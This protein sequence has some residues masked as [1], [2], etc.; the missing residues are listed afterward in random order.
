MSSDVTTKAK[1]IS[2]SSGFEHGVRIGL[3]AY[4]IVHLLI[5]WLGLQAAFGEGS[6]T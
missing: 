4:G 5:G 6:G 2:D 3:V 1:S